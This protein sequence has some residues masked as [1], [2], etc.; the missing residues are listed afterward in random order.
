MDIFQA[1][2][3]TTDPSFASVT[4]YSMFD[5]AAYAKGITVEAVGA[6]VLFVM[7][8]GWGLVSFGAILFILA[9]IIRVFSV[10]FKSPRPARR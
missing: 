10:G 2:A 6:P 5:F 4:G 1:L 7:Q 9:I 3:S 8:H